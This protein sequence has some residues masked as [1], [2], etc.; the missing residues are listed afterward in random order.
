MSKASADELASLHAAVAQG[1]SKAIT[2]GVPVPVTTKDADGEKVTVLEYAPAGAAYYAAAIALLKNNNITA[3]PKANKDLD[4]LRES[5]EKK[6]RDGK[7]GLKSLADAT[8][9]FA[10]RL[11]MQ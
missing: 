9:D 5:L 3:D 11:P 2:D 4:D 1:L 8:A 6:R 7:E 10:A